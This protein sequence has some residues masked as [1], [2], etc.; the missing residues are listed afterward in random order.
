M[1]KLKKKKKIMLRNTFLLGGSW[2]V[3]KIGYEANTYSLSCYS[4]INTIFYLHKPNK[5]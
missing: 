5:K 1:S 4:S 2:A 3:Y